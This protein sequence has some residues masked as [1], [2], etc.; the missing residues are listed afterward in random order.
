MKRCGARGDITLHTSILVLAF[1]L[2]VSASTSMLLY[3]QARRAVLEGH[4]YAASLLAGSEQA[5]MGAVLEHGGFRSLAPHPLPE[6][7]GETERFTS[8]WR[9]FD[10]SGACR[11]LDLSIVESIGRHALDRRV[12]AVAELA[13]VAGC[14][15][16]PDDAQGSALWTVGGFLPLSTNPLLPPYDDPGRSRSPDSCGPMSARTD[17]A[18][19]WV[20]VS[21]SPFALVYERG[22]TDTDTDGDGLLDDDGDGLPEYVDP[23]LRLASGPP[24]PVEHH[25]AGGDVMCALWVQQMHDTADSITGTAF[26]VDDQIES[27]WSQETLQVCGAAPG[28]GAA[29]RSVGGSA[30]IELQDEGMNPVCETA[31][32]AIR[33]GAADTAASGMGV[34][35]A[36]LAQAVSA[37]HG[38]PP[39]EPTTADCQAGPPRVDV[40]A[41]GWIDVEWG[42]GT[43]ASWLR[44]HEE[45]MHRAVVVNGNDY[46]L[47]GPVHAEWLPPD[48][49]SP[50][51]TLDIGE[52]TIFYAP[53]LMRLPAMAI[54]DGVDVAFI[55]DCAIEVRGSIIAR[56]RHDP[57]H[58]GIPD[59]TTSGT[60][61]L[62][63]SG[64]IWVNPTRDGPGPPWPH[65]ALCPDP[66]VTFDSDDPLDLGN[67]AP[68]AT[69]CDNG[70]FLRLERVWLAA[71]NGGIYA[72]H[73]L[74]AGA[75]TGGT[76]GT[77]LLE[78]ASATD[79]QGVVGLNRPDAV[80]TVKRATGWARIYRSPPDALDYLDNFHL[81]QP[82]WWP[83]PSGWEPS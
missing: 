24:L 44:S 55:S 49:D 28:M 9:C 62:I 4:R 69:A 14:A 82:A 47:G 78:G 61:A 2:I 16:M 39:A 67:I 72:A 34:D 79:W 42:G 65:G 40:I 51:R 81:A 50:L 43:G 35:I 73:A 58:N 1:V 80:G 37:L 76:V 18:Q 12:S 6:R 32:S 36:S 48:A 10:E 30:G 70:R 22:H 29:D 46:F 5:A 66:A 74:S 54:P 60:A 33:S 45:L 52:D 31:G 25:P 3:T 59:S 8:G 19:E 7:P 83:V 13:V 20:F 68:G 27:A 64:D 56:A 75:A 15:A 11:R 57:D 41:D 71:P 23:C 26:T 63:T 17:S 38:G 21:P 77:I 53:N